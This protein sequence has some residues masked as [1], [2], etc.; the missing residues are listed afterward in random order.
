MNYDYMI[1]HIISE[2]IV[3]NRPFPYE[4]INISNYI[5]KFVQN[6]EQSEKEKQTFWKNT[7]CTRSRQTSN[8]PA[9]RPVYHGRETLQTIID[10]GIYKRDLELTQ[11]RFSGRRGMA[12]LKFRNPQASASPKK[13]KERNPYI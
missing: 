2:T 13:Q 8:A 6:A 1:P 7:K 3:G 10:K 11:Y 5:T 4:S 12:Q 9:V